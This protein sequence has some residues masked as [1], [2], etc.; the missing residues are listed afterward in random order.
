[1]A[2][3]KRRQAEMI[4][5]GDAL[6]SE[7]RSQSA[8]RAWLTTRPEPIVRALAI[9]LGLPDAAGGIVLTPAQLVDQILAAEWERTR[10]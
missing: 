3:V 1:M 2:S 10:K 4:T 9:A 8:T 5:V 7:F 6:I